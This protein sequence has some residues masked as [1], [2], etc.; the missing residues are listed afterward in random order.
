MT[1]VKFAFANDKT[2]KGTVSSL[3]KIKEL[4]SDKDVWMKEELNGY[5]E[6]A[7]KATYCL[8]GAS[9]FIDG[10]YETYV[11]AVMLANLGETPIFDENG[12]LTTRAAVADYNDAETRRHFDIMKFLDR[13][14]ESA[15]T[16]DI[17]PKVVVFG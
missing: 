3:K 14:I 15:E 8:L 7:D 9:K 11:D 1:K 13:C 10:P 17:A 4:L 6:E 16:A 2:R 5:N 12:Y